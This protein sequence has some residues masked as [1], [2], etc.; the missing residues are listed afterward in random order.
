MNNSIQLQEGETILV[1][2][3]R[4]WF[5]LA[6]EGAV[7]TITFVGVCILAG[8]LDGVLVGRAGFDVAHSSA[9]TVYVVA[10]V[11]LLLWSRFFASWSDHWLDAWILTNKHFI[12]IEQKGFFRREVQTFQLDR[13]QDVTCD[14]SGIIA[15]WLHFGNIRIQTASITN[16]LILYQIPEPESVK[17]RIMAALPRATL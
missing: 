1:T 4:H 8:V 2:V 3:R 15:T 17:E 14:V 11:G 10:G 5:P 9:L 13:V 12:I 6:V 16:D 7:D